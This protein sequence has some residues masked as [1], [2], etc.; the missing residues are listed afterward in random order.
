MLKITEDKAPG[1]YVIKS[2][3]YDAREDRVL[4]GLEDGTVVS[5]TQ[6]GAEKYCPA[7]GDTYVVKNRSSVPTIVDHPDKH[8]NLRH[9]PAPPA[10]AGAPVMVTAETYSDGGRMERK[11]LL[12]K[13]GMMGG[14]TAAA[15]NPTEDDATERAIQMAGKTAP[16]VIPAQIKAEVVSEHYFTAAQGVKGTAAPEQDCEHIPRELNLLT[17]CVLVLVNGFTVVGTSACASPENFDE[18]I[19]RDIARQNAEREIWPLLGFRLRDKLAF[20]EPYDFSDD[21]E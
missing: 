13:Q 18:K 10:S 19:G 6:L 15:I 1:T 16:R 8:K 2:V 9:P 17:V 4:M 3:Q 12:G 14:A 20:G 5:M 21:G 7:P 11:T